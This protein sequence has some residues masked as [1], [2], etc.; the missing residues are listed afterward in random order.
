MWTKFRQCLLGSVL[1]VCLGLP[2]VSVASAPTE[3]SL[4]TMMTLLRFDELSQRNIRTGME[5]AID[6]MLDELQ[7][8]YAFDD[9]KRAELK[10]VS[11][12]YAEQRLALFNK[13]NILLELRETYV[14]IF[15]EYYTQAEVDAFNQFLSTETGVS[16]IHKQISLQMMAM[17]KEAEIATVIM[18]KYQAEFAKIDEEMEEQI[19]RI[20]AE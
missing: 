3:E 6:V 1:C 15:R 4:N 11:M 17:Q 5:F 13:E 2:V 9:K 16:A 10:E 14:A 18:D 7:A 19:F 8:T 12:R 20:V